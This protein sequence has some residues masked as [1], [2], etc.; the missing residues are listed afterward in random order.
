MKDKQIDIEEVILNPRSW[1][2]A[3]GREE[4]DSK[5]A[6]MPVGFQRPPTLAEQVQRLVRSAISREAE[7]KGFETFEESEDFDIPDDP[8]D[9]ATP[10]ETVFDPVL[11]HDISADEWRKNEARYR[12]RYETQGAQLTRAELFGAL[13]IDP[14]EYPSGSAPRREAGG[15]S[16][17]AGAGQREAPHGPLDGDGG[18]T[19]QT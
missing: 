12:E 16:Q 14:D 9:P 4:A 7:E 8:I 5:P 6:A 13:G 18:A 17:G 1:G 15:S 3:P 2:P 11:G 19:P 10:Y